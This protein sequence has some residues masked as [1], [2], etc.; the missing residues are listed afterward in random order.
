MKPQKE[1]QSKKN[2]LLMWDGIAKKIVIFAAVSAGILSVLMIA[3]YLQTKSN[4]P[5]NSQVITQ[6]IAQLQDNPEDTVLKEQIRALDLLARKAYFTYQW[7]IRTGSY[8]LF[9]FVLL[10]LLALKFSSSLQPRLPDLNTGPRSEEGWENKLSSRKYILFGGLGVFALALILGMVSQSEL[11]K[12]GVAKRG[13][14]LA[15]DFA[16]IKE[17]KEN[18]PGFRG[19]EGN[20]VA[21]D[22]DFPTEW[23]G[24]AGEN[25]LWKIP[26]PHPGYNSPIV[27][28]KKIFLSGADR[29][30]QIVYCIDAD[31]GDILWQTELIDIPGSPERRPSVGDDTGYAAPTMTTDGE[32]VFAL[33]ATGDIACLDLEGK[34]IWAKNLGMPDNHYGHSSSLITFQDLLIVP[35]DQNTGGRLLALRAR[36]GDMVYDQPR[37]VEISW[38]SPILINTG[39]R[40]ELILSSNP[41]VMS[42]DPQTGEEL[43]R[44][45]CMLGEVAP[46]PAYADGMVFAVNDYARLV[47]IK[48]QETPEVV[49]EYIDDLSEVA[50]LLATKDFVFMAASFGTVSCFDSKSG[51]RYWFHDFDEGFYSSPILV[52]DKVYC[53]DMFGVMVIFKADKKFELISQNDLGEHAMTIP[54]FMHN[55]IYIRGEKNLFCIGK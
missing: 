50:S 23:D 43:W 12:I 55:R 4:D 33:F 37:D 32:R 46:S 16:G 13:K 14:S 31:S 26:I 11:K 8:L 47:G 25:I 15:S 48:L 49:W 20:G 17:M 6:L 45:Q 19:P 39:D 40:S 22:A 2:S 24:P 10:I 54:A 28:G 34:R 9:A 53:M 30:I 21:V 18:W 29:E 44:V 27:W 51:E 52:G 41:F 36:S 7:Q 42:H 35:F 1:E 38:A 3:N 5:L